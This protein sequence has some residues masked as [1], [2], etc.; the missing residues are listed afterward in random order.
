MARPRSRFLIALDTSSFELSFSTF[1]FDTLKNGS[2]TS[3]AERVIFE[4]VEIEG[5]EGSLNVESWTGG[6]LVAEI[7]RT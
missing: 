3:F 1:D 6:R 7:C 4:A 5:K 2:E